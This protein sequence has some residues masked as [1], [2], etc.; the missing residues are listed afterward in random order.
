M[1]TT[2]SQP[3]TQFISPSRSVWS[4]SDLNSMASLPSSV[5]QQTDENRFA[6]Q[7]L[8]QPKNYNFD[9]D[10]RTLK[11]EIQKES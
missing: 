5:P 6:M 3:K 1:N 2:C 11:R 9:K 4:M 7:N 8:L 10:M